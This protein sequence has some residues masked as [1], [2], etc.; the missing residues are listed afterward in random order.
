MSSCFSYPVSRPREG[1]ARSPARAGRTSFVAGVVAA[2]SLLALLGATAWADLFFQA[3]LSG[4]QEVPPNASAGT[5]IGTFTL[6]TATNMLSFNI[7]YGG[8]GGIE[9]AAHIHSPALAGVNAGVLFPLPAA[10]PKIGVVGPLTP[11]QVTDLRNGKMYA[12]I[13][14]TIF[15]GGEIRGQLNQIDNL[16][17]HAVLSF[18][19]APG[20]EAKV[21][22]VIGS[23]VALVGM[24]DVESKIGFVKDTDGN[25]REQV[26]IEILAMSLSGFDPGLGPVSLRLRPQPLH[27]FQKTRGEMEEQVN[28][29]NGRLDVPPYAPG[30]FVESF[31][32]VFFEVELFGGAVFH[33]DVPIRLRSTNSNVPPAMGEVFFG[34]GPVP[35]VDQFDNPTGLQAFNVYHTPVPP[36]EHDDFSSSTATVELIGLLNES[37]SLS[38]PT[39]VDVT[40]KPADTNNNGLEQVPTEMVALSLSGSSSVGPLTV[41]LRPETAS[42]FMR[43]LGE[44]EENANTMAGRLDLPPFAPSGT[45]SSFF[46]VFFE[47][48]I[49]SMGMILHNRQPKHMQGVITRKPPGP[50]DYYFSPDIIQLYDQNDVPVP[51]YL[52]Q[53]RHIP[54]PPDTIEVDYFANSHAVMDVTGPWGFDQLVLNG[55][56]QV[57]V[58]IMPG[59]MGAMDTDF[60]GLDQVRTEMV[61]MDLMSPG[62][63]LGHVP[64]PVMVHLN[65]SMMTMGEIEEDA[66]TMPGRLDMPPFAPSGMGDS[67]FDVFFELEVPGYPTLHNQTPVNV[68]G[69]IRHKPPDPGDTYYKQGAVQLYDPAGNPVP[70]TIQ[71]T[72]HTPD[73]GGGNVAV[74]PGQKPA[75]L[76]IQ[77]IRPNPTAGTTNITLALP[78]RA[79]TKLLIYDIG[80]RTV[81]TL[82]N[83]T[84]DAGYRNVVWDTKTDRG[85][86]V[87]GGVYFMRL[88][89]GGRLA[90]R[91]VVVS[92]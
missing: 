80:G 82:V 68:R 18:G 29:L 37:V 55:P 45:A 14:T 87:A 40:L 25:L 19:P 33:N 1:G 50:G 86:P 74:E 85:K 88:E 57:N 66:N 64:G 22:G 69:R 46:D 91:R 6:N 51:L 4:A 39:K 16:N 3:E 2:L 83:A 28:T 42:P 5:G 75:A 32:D 52:G 30:G 53:T 26:P 59:G 49:P 13:H 81:R 48:D 20:A 58:H 67:F 65:R 15:P 77:E 73:T 71:V 38:G 76:A 79:Q 70:I 8:L 17:T 27:P 92:R 24:T 89:S 84:M 34:P 21:A 78:A 72:R 36:I 41:N 35:L 54:V 11:A 23:T 7:A 10:N 90:V 44:I 56:T 62:G 61:A 63:S 43:T 60:D 47:V 31:F 9:T 12:N